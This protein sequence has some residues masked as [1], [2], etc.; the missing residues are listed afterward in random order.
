VE[1]NILANHIGKHSVPGFILISNLRGICEDL[2]Y[3]AYLSRLEKSKANELISHLL[4]QNTANGIAAQKDFFAINNPTQP[5]LGSG[6]SPDQSKQ[7]VQQ[8]RATLQLFWTSIG[9]A[10]S[11]GLTVRDLAR[12]VGLSS[13]YEYIYFAASNFVHFNPQAL[14]RTGWGRE[15]GPFNFSIYNMDGYY[16]SFSSFYGAVLFIGFQAAFG[17][18]YLRVDLD[19][20]I[21]Q[22]IELIGYVQRWPEVITFEEMTRY[23]LCTCSRTL[24]EKL[25]LKRVSRSRM[26]LF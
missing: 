15:H 8:A 23:H 16:K 20:E 2:I 5:V 18:E 4:R 9:I 21:A 10:K 11:D 1:F 26:G 14:F 12:N 17:G 24:C 3:L 6:L 7:H 13:T 19:A 22:L 25:C